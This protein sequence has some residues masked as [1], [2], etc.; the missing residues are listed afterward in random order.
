MHSLSAGFWVPDGLT[1]LHEQKPKQPV[2]FA[3]EGITANGTQIKHLHF[4]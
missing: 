1:L 4:A 2:L 3:F